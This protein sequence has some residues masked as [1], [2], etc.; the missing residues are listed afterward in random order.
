MPEQFPS[1]AGL[2]ARIGVRRMSFWRRRISRHWRRRRQRRDAN[3]ALLVVDA[4]SL[5]RHRALPAGQAS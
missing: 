4:L 5:A 2:R 3:V 1:N